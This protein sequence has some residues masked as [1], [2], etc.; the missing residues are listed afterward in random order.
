MAGSGPVTF[1]HA[2]SGSLLDV[3]MVAGPPVDYSFKELKNCMELETEEPQRGPRRKKPED[4]VAAVNEDGVALPGGD[5]KLST[6]NTSLAVANLGKAAPARTIA[7]THVKKIIRQVTM[8]VKLNNNF[9]ETIHDLPIALDFVMDDPL[10]NCRWIDLSFN[11]LRTI[12][13]ALLE[14]QQ[15]KALYLHGN[16]IKA[17]PSVERLKKL[18][19]L[20]S[21]TLNGNPI[22]CGRV[23]RTYVIGAL[24]HLRSLDHSMVTEEEVQGAVVWFKA[25]LKRLKIRKEMQEQS[26]IFDE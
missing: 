25:H 5:G 6:Q 20:I 15:L 7:S 8:A 11:L 3:D 13:P 2:A 24:P 4:R 1:G 22:E 10:R 16:Q 21:L 23:Y 17:L 14:F 26:A 18:P 19:K 9:I 12:E